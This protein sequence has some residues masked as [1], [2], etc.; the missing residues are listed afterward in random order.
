M[1]SAKTHLQVSW[2]DVSSRKEGAHLGLLLLGGVLSPLHWDILGDL[3]PRPICFSLS[4]LESSCGCI[5]GVSRVNSWTCGHEQRWVNALLSGPEDLELSFK[6][7]EIKIEY[8]HATG[9]VKIAAKKVRHYS[10]EYLWNQK[11][12][13]GNYLPRC[14]TEVMLT[15]KILVTKEKMGH[16]VP[17]RWHNSEQLVAELI[18]YITIILSTFIINSECLIVHII[19]KSYKDHVTHKGSGHIF[20]LCPLIL[21][22]S[23]AYQ[24]RKWLLPIPMKISD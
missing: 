16:R 1:S 9:D 21:P 8:G 10:S 11:W 15:S 13:F 7:L 19:E 17:E 23:N 4:T 18:V 20:L 5:C 3:S 12:K 24:G 6:H 14:G 22:L 2:A